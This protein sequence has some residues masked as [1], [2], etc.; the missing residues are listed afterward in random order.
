MR[1]GGDRIAAQGRLRN[2]RC[3]YPPRLEGTRD[4][5]VRKVDNGKL[6]AIQ[7]SDLSVDQAEE[8]GAVAEELGAV[9]E[10]WIH[11]LDLVAIGLIDEEQVPGG[12]GS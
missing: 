5:F 6:E 3:R 1:T 9:A 7:A 4:L 12:A 2:T 11:P 8:R 10:E